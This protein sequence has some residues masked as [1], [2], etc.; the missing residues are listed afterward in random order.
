MWR[1]VLAVVW[2]CVFGCCVEV[3]D[4][5]VCV[6]LLCVGVCWLLCGGEVCG[7]V[8]WLLCGGVC[9]AVVWNY[10]CITYLVGKG[11]VSQTRR[12]RGYVAGQ[13]SGSRYRG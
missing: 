6:W 7:G 5:V 13:G 9:L 4:V 12:A 2:R 3:C 10:V 11:Q 8:C 1:C